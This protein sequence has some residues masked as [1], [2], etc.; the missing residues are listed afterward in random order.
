MHAFLSDESYWVCVCAARLAE[1]AAEAM[2]PRH[3]QL[4]HL[5]HA[6]P[7]WRALDPIAAAE[8]HAGRSQSP[9]AA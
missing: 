8:T 2:G 4:A 1:L 7:A 3:E 5:L 9:A 6:D